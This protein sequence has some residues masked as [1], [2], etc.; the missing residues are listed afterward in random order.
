MNI[1]LPK[2]PSR[3]D[4]GVPVGSLGGIQAAHRPHQEIIFTVAHVCSDSFLITLLSIIA[5]IVIA[6]ITV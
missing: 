1:R 3:A 6:I 2:G 5:I 4:I